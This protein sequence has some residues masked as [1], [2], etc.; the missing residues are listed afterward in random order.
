[1]DSAQ[2]RVCWLELDGMNIAGSGAGLELGCGLRAAAGL[3]DA[4]L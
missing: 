4:G 2:C 1:M 3:Y